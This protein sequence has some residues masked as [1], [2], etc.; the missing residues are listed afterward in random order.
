VLK[1]YLQ[2]DVI[3]GIIAFLLIA[4]LGITSNNFSI[5]KLRSAWKKIQTLSYPLFLIVAIHIAFASRFSLFYMILIGSLIFLRTLAF[6]VEKTTP[7]ITTVKATKYLCVP[8][9]Y[10]YDEEK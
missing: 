10:I 4:I 2:F 7:L 1:D 5:Q 3:S 8:C 6:L 9:G